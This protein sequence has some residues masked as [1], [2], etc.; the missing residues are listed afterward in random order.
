M[1]LITLMVMVQLPLAGIFAAARVTLLVVLVKD[2]DAPPH[3]VVGAGM[4]AMVRLAGSVC[5]RPDCVNAKPLLLLNVNVSVDAALGATL[6]GEN[7]S[8]TTGAIG[9]TVIG[10][11]HALALPPA[12]AGALLV[13]VP[14]EKVT[15]AASE[16][17][18]ESVTLSTNVPAAP[19]QV[20][21]AC[22]A[23]CPEEMVTP[24]VE[25]HA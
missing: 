7:A 9:V 23:A 2:I 18:A 17:L 10:M 20:T 1:A 14:A 8:L 19:F 25:V 11:G 13:A 15:V 3:V 22:A 16:L 21:M 12:D 5:V 4:A 24:P 6:A